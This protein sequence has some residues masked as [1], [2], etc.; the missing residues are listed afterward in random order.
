MNSPA[1]CRLAIVLYATVAQLSFVSA[2][3]VDPAGIRSLL[4]AAWNSGESSARIVTGP[5]PAMFRDFLRANGPLIANVRRESRFAEK[6]CARYAIEFVQHG[7]PAETG[8]PAAVN[9]MSVS[10]NHC[11]D[12]SAP[13]SGIDMDVFGELMTKRNR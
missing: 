4:A 2:E 3:T 10:L 5:L 13:G 9:V 1:A 11:L 7:V 8:S 12:G 6:G